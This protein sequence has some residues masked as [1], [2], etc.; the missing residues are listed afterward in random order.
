MWGNWNTE[1]LSLI[2]AIVSRTG[3]CPALQTSS[4]SQVSA[5]SSCQPVPRAE[6]VTKAGSLFLELHGE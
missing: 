4:L 1:K 6:V 5:E 3:Q 2:Y